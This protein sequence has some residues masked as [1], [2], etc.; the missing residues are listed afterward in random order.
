M[1]H[2]IMDQVGHGTS[3]LLILIMMQRPVL[4]TLGT[5]EP[6]RV[7]IIPPSFCLRDFAIDSTPSQ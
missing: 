5:A 2:G 7:H 4:G 3:D 1:K 6:A